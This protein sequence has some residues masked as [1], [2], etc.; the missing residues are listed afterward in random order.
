MRASTRYVSRFP[1]FEIN[2]TCPG[3]TGA[4]LC[5]LSW[6][7]FRGMRSTKTKIRMT[8]TSYCHVP[9]SYDQKNVRERIWPRLAISIRRHSVDDN[10]VAHVNNAVEIGGCFRVVRDHDD[11]LAQIFIQLPQHLQHDFRVFRIQVSCGFIGEENLRLIDDRPRDGHALL[12]TAGKLR[13]LVMKTSR[14]T[15]H[16]RYDIEAVRVESV[17]MNKLRDGDIALGRQGGEQIETLKDEADFV[18]AQFGARGVAQFGE[19]ITVDQNLAPGSLRQAADHIQQRRLA[20]SRRPHHRDRFAR[21]HLE[22]HPTQRR[23]FDFSRAVEFPQVFCS[24]YRLHALFSLENQPIGRFLYCSCDSH[25]C[26]AIPPASRSFPRF[27]VSSAFLVLFALNSLCPSR[28][29]TL[30]PRPFGSPSMPDSSRRTA[31]PGARCRP[32]E[33]S[34]RK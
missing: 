22:I 13:G 27:S 11:G 9:R 18:A 1:S 28:T 17:A 16:L 34:I 14:Q 19:I 7:Q 33:E 23:D 8:A 6:N 5:G 31:R 30:Q 10:S 15:E 12:L 32:R 25:S 4:P 26:L 29:T 20:A 21:L 24:E 3:V 2:W